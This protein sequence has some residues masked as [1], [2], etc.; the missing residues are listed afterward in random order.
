MTP[1]VPAQRRH[2]SLLELTCGG[3][4]LRVARPWSAHLSGSS[5]RDPRGPGFLMEQALIGGTSRTDHGGLAGYGWESVPRK[6]N[7]S[8]SNDA[9]TGPCDRRGRSPHSAHRCI[10]NNRNRSTTLHTRERSSG[11]RSRTDH[12]PG[13]GAFGGISPKPSRSGGKPGWSKEVCIICEPQ[14][15]ERRPCLPQMKSTSG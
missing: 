6:M 10:G 2:R 9:V 14:L 5:R 1:P 7:R 12:G 4:R 15:S 3:R 11:G 13:R 8:T